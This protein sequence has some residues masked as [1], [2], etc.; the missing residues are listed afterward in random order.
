MHDVLSFT[1]SEIPA[2]KAFLGRFD[3]QLPPNQ[4]ELVRC[5]VSGN[6]LILFESGKLVIQGKNTEPL[7]ERI[8]KELSKTTEEIILGID[9]TGRGENTGDFC[10]AGVLGKT[11]DLREVRDSKKTAN[12][13]EKKKIVEQ[14]A[15]NA[16]VL[17]YSAETID[18]LRNEGVNLNQIEG[19]AID[20]ISDF[21]EQNFPKP[22]K[23][24][25]DGGYLPVQNK[26]IEFLPRADDLEPV[27]SAASILARAARLEGDTK[28]LRKTWKTKNKDE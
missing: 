22:Q 28:T 17:C 12:I 13:N 2:I 25:V 24:I 27:V 1:K 6:T 14:K 9:E 20:W 11:G 4:Y 3:E 7:K 21:F 26:K 18:A 16:V 10:I 15:L 8:L 19:Q 23:I 5:K